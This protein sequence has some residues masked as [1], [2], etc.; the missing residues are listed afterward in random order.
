MMQIERIPASVWWLEIKADDLSG[1]AEADLVA[2]LSPAEWERWDGMRFPKRREEW[3]W[4]RYV[5]KKLLRSALPNQ[6]AGIGDTS[7]TIR[8]RDTGEPYVVR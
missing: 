6:L 8:N 7:V 4:G 1:L 2:V 3:L 5:A